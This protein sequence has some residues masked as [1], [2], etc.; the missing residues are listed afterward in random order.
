MSK[1]GLVEIK[2]AIHPIFDLHRSRI[3][4]MKSINDNGCDP[5]FDLK[6]SD[7]LHIFNPALFHLRG[8][9]LENIKKWVLY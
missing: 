6:R 3:L 4:I 7:E 5:I 2:K 1:L 9:Q 8:N